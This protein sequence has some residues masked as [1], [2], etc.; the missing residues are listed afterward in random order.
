MT[1][2]YLSGHPLE[3]YEQ[4]LKLQTSIK[5]SDMLIDEILEEVWKK[6]VRSR[7]KN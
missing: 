6:S 3:E 7:S 1:G 4:T 5:T 2:M